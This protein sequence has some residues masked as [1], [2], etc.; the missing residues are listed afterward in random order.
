MNEFSKITSKYGPKLRCMR[1][2]LSK[3]NTK[4]YKIRSNAT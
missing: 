2:I 1:K 3:N 4:D